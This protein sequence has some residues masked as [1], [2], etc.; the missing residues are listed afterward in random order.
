[1]LKPSTCN[2]CQLATLGNF[3]SKPSGQGRSGVI[4]IGEALDFEGSLQGFPY[5]PKSQGGSKL[6]E[7]FRLAGFVRDD[8]YITN[9]IR[10][11]P[12]KGQVV[13]TWYGDGAIR[14]CTDSFLKKDVL[15]FTPPASKRK[16]ILTMGTTAFQTLTGK[17]ETVAEIRGYPYVLK[18]DTGQEA[19][20]IT[21]I[22]TLHPSFI[23]RGQGHLTPLLVADIQK[24]VAIAGQ[25]DWETPERDRIAGY[26]ERIPF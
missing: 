21:V 1:M 7:C 15:T 5:P 8:F 26:G 4:I 3:F 20:G 16:V 22:P 23:K 24:A 25:E 6:E 18:W 9:L 2:S 12:P 17:Y 19:Q 13:N 11:H 10:C 14:M